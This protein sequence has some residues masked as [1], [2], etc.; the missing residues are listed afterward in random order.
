MTR[1]DFRTVIKL[2]LIITVITVMNASLT[3]SQLYKLN[4]A[5]SMAVGGGISLIVIVWTIIRFRR[6]FFQK[7]VNDW[8]E[9]E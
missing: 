6:L 4:T 9:A 1:E 7:R 2:L 3:I 8:L 5:T